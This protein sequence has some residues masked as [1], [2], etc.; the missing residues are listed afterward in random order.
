MSTPLAGRVALVTGASRGIGAAIAERLAAA[1]AAV[2]VTARSLDEAPAH[3]P[4]TLRDVVERIQRRGGRAVALAADLTDPAARA[5]LVE[6]AAAAALG[7]VDVLVNN[8]AA[9]FYIPFEKI[10][11]KRYR[12]MMELNVHAPFDLAQQA[13]AGMRA[14][15]RGWIVNV[16]SATAMHPQ[17]PPY[18]DFYKHG[19]ATLYGLSKAALDRLTTGL[20]AETAGDGVAVNSIAPVAA[21]L[22][23][24]VAALGVVP[25]GH[26]ELLE[27]VE[28]I[29][30]ATLALA[31]CAPD[32]ETGRI[33]YTRSFLA[34]RG[35]VPHTLDGARPFTEGGL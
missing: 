28:L 16:S 24:G 5:G 3:L 15:R 19:G 21:V 29:A 26:P 7:P 14:R 8:A 25:E 10:T 30:E 6:R 33:L 1:G 17:G 13:L 27:P 35:L 4:G 9:A 34:E 23:P 32:A 18:P 12:V 2:A 20:A 22:T 31:T 11:E